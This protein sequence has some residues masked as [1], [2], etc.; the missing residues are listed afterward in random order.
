MNA[1]IVKNQLGPIADY[2][3]VFYPIYFLGKVFFSCVP[4]FIYLLELDNYFTHCET[5]LEYG[6]KGKI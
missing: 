6:S 5:V 4:F 1:D 3:I 2:K